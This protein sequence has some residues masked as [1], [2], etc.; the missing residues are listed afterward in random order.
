MKE[1]EVG[2]YY[3]ARSLKKPRLMNIYKVVDCD[4]AF[5]TIE[6]FYSNEPQRL[7][8]RLDFDGHYV[9]LEDDVHGELLLSAS[10]EWEMPSEALSHG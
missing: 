9:M 5:A 8:I 7:P 10:N 6:R 4:R 3:F 2:K 1:F